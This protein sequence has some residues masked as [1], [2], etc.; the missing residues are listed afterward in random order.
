ME[1]LPLPA[2]LAVLPP[3]PTWLSYLPKSQGHC[4]LGGETGWRGRT[5]DLAVQVFQMNPNA[6]VCESHHTSSSPQGVL[7]APGEALICLSFHLSSLSIP[8]PSLPV[9]SSLPLSPSAMSD[10]VPTEASPAVCSCNQRPP[11]QH[12]R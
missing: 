2:Y 12:S 4:S 11:P 6:E 9:S 8:L 10:K 3:Q 7:C 5:L 1:G